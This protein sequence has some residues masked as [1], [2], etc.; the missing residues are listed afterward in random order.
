MSNDFIGSRQKCFCCYLH[1]EYLGA[2]RQHSLKN[3][4]QFWLINMQDSIWLKTTKKQKSQSKKKEQN[5]GKDEQNFCVEKKE[6]KINKNEPTRFTASETED[7]WKNAK[8]VHS[9]WSKQNAC[10]VDFVVVAVVCIECRKE[11]ESAENIKYTLHIGT[12]DGAAVC[13]WIIRHLVNII[14]CLSTQ[15]QLFSLY[16]VP[17]FLLVSLIR[18][19]VKAKQ[20]HKM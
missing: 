12:D 13:W 18:F 11:R 16:L 5:E 7:K 1:S 17:R 19:W 4:L 8:R 9:K 14:A 15:I 6:G 20:M 3:Q 10:T 2:A